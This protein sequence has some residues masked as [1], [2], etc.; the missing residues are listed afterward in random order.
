MLNSQHILTDLLPKKH[1]FFMRSFDRLFLCT[2]VL[3]NLLCHF[4]TETAIKSFSNKKSKAELLSHN[5]LERFTEKY[6]LAFPLK[7]SL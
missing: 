6:L 7:F 4:S 1:Y 5:Y 3:V 2:I